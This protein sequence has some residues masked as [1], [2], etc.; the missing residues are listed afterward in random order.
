LGDIDQ[1]DRGLRSAQAKTQD[2]IYT[3]TKAKQK[4]LGCMA[5]VIECLSSKD[6]QMFKPQYHKKF[7]E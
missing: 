3:I 2:P 4:V 5:Q 6:L 7:K 1:E